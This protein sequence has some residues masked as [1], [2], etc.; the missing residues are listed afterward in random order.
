M[1]FTSLEH[2]L[3]WIVWPKPEPLAPLEMTIE[4]PGR[5]STQGHEL[6]AFNED[7]L[8][9]RLQCLR[10]HD[11]EAITI[12]L[13]NSFANPAHEVLARDIVRQEFPDSEC[14]IASIC[15][16]PYLY[17]RHLLSLYYSPNL[18]FL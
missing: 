11:P 5:I 2:T 16:L 8:R 15:G 18:H 4:V 6:Q 9:A 12:S 14:S 3:G 10:I 7:V 13:I 1:Q 17:N